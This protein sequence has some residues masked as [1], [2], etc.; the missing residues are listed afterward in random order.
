M[1][2]YY[3][4]DMRMTWGTFRVDRK[5]L[6]MRV[7]RWADMRIYLCYSSDIRNPNNKTYWMHMRMSL[8]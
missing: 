3:A 8:F 2:G 6:R 7:R 4:A 1:R 5:L